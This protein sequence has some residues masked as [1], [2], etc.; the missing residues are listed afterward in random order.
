LRTYLLTFTQKQHIA[1]REL[2][3]TLLLLLLTKR[4]I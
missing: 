4:H 2:L 1:Q 3:L